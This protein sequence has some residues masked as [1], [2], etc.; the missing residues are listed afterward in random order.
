MTMLIY[1]YDPETGRFDGSREARAW[2]GREG[3]PD[4]DLGKWQISQHATHL[5]PPETAAGE[6]ACFIDG[7]WQVVEDH[8][9]ETVFSTEDGRPVFFDKPGPLPDGLT[10]EPRPDA[11]H[12][13]QD[14]AWAPDDTL[15]REA[16]EIERARRLAA[17]FDF[18]FGDAR[19]VHRIGTTPSDLAGW[20]EVTTLAQ[21]MINAGQPDGQITIVTD[22]G[23]ANITAT[24][25]QSIL[26]AA[27]NFRQPIW[28]A[29][30][31]LQAMDEIPLDF[32]ADGYWP[33]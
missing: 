16:V 10:T 28:A 29:S 27:A 33:A 26:I 12:S 4:D 25:W 21:A 18:A 17:G 23:P 7:S 31:A 24:E 22:T 9:K 1:D 13:W 15:L 14:G 5:A 11:L 2:P 6:A 19:G 20:D 3:M 8:S 30:F 32:A